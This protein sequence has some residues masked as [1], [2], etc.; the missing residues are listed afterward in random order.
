MSDKG[1]PPRDISWGW[2]ALTSGLVCWAFVLG[3]LV[4]QGVLAPQSYIT[5]ALAWFSPADQD[6]AD[7]EAAESKL[8]KPELSFYNELLDR[9]SPSQPRPA[10]AAEKGKKEA[11]PAGPRY[12]VQ[13]ASYRGKDQAD[14]LAQKLAAN[15]HPAFVVKA[16][17]KEAGSRFRVRVGDFHEKSQA[18]ALARRL[19]LQARLAA[20]V[21]RK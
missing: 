19:R 8:T 20:Y 14:Q 6:E 15:G 7:P 2:V 11:A 17:L 12:T 4:G 16:N 9:P 18:D 10:K 5:K 21:V 13:V 1:R 3:L